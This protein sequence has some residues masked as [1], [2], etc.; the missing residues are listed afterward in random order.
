VVLRDG[1]ARPG[2]R[3]L[4]L[5]RGGGLTSPAAR[6]WLEALGL[7]GRLP[8]ARFL[9][10]VFLRFQR[11]VAYETLTRPAGE[12]AGFD[13]EA[14]AAEWPG[15]ERGLTGEERARAFAW[16]AG[17]LGFE[18]ALEEALCFRPWATA[19]RDEGRWSDG[20][21]GLSSKANGPAAHRSVVAT[22]GGRRLLVDAGFPLPVPIPLHVP[23]NE[24][25]SSFGTLSLEPGEGEG[26]G[27]RVTCDARGEVAELLRLRP[28]RHPGPVPPEETPGPSPAVFPAQGSGGSEFPFALRVLDDRVLHWADG[29]M[30]ILDGWSALTYPL[31]G[32]ERRAF[33]SLFALNLDGIELPRVPAAEEPAVL[34]VFHSL[35]LPPEEARQALVLAEPPASL[36]ASRTIDVAPARGGSRLSARAVL[37]GVVPQEGPGESVR[38]TLVFHLAMELLGAGEGPGG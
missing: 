29:R 27:I 13:P 31:A 26:G 15:E 32:D 6:A 19:E 7:E 4:A 16:L 30:T 17:E 25:S 36:V 21:G 34:T 20:E 10:D 24:I 22:V 28:A 14:F 5:I 1:P 18:V 33:E 23:S 11:R 12:A 3:P 37:A 35:A 2:A 38:R 9:E 8:D